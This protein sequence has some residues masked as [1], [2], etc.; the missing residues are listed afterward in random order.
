MASS[1]RLN[2][3]E[4]YSRLGINDD[5]DEGLVL[6]GSNEE[7][8]GLNLDFCLVG[9]FLTWRKVNFSAMQDTLSS[10]W[11]PVKGVFMEE[12][13]VPNLYLFRFFHELDVQRVLD[14]GPWTFNNQALMVKRL[15][16]GE[17]LSDIALNELY[18]WVQIYDLSVGFNSEFI[19]K[20]IGNYIG[21]FLKADTKNFQ[22]IWRQ[23]MRIKVALNVHKPLKGQ[24]R[25]KKQGGEW[26]WVKF[27]YERLPSFCFYCGIIGHSE[28]FCEKLFDNA[29]TAENRKYD[30]SIRAPMRNQTNA[31]KNQ[32]LRNDEGGRLGRT[33]VE[34]G[35]EDD[36]GIV[37]DDKRYPTKSGI[38][39]KVGGKIGDVT[40]NVNK[41]GS[42]D[43][44][45]EKDMENIFSTITER[46]NSN[47]KT[48]GGN[49]LGDGLSVVD[50]KRRR[51]DEGLEDGLA[52]EK[53]QVDIVMLETQDISLMN[54]KNELEAGAA[55][56][57]RLGL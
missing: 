6:E 33:T 56:Q 53:N 28:K 55:M 23:F 43:N 7:V 2:I 4:E 51:L 19:L 3:E 48:V 54:Q 47:V 45:G 13:N 30:A 22:S 35:G 34:E 46:E 16:E 8:Q 11:R 17:Q 1:S 37:A 50:P 32:W 25:I 49:K 44:T 15:E 10:I 18:M 5:D 21:R 14:D 52:Q 9:S 31:V 39:Q 40:D 57:A 42:K 36:R 24:M 27:K 12:T 29:G 41:G 26:V 38:A 20:C